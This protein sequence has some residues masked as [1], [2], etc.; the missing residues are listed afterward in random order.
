MAA[1]EAREQ[2]QFQQAQ[3][4]LKQAIKPEKSR[5]QSRDP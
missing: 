2:Q 5:E 3:A 1:N 4:A